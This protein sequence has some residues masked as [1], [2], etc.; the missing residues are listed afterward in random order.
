MLDAVLRTEALDSRFRAYFRMAE[1][2][3][4]DAAYICRLRA[5]P[6]LN[7]HLNPS[8]TVVE[9][10]K[11]WLDAYKAR[12]AEGCEFYFV[13]MHDGADAGV[14]RMYDFRLD[15]V[16]TS[17]AWGSWIVPAPRPAGLVTFSALMIYEVAFD[18]LGFQQAHFTVRK[19]N[20]GVI[21]F[22]LRAGARQ[23][24]E[25]DDEFHFVYSPEAYRQLRADSEERYAAL[26]RLG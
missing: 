19:D 25:D 12:E 2:T 16:P 4:R 3:E 14:V 17:F 11:R 24:D 26:R 8:S 10:Q 22:H 18:A 13:I 1:P 7:Q 6:D 21:A 23:V 5:D 20:S 9:D 15:Q